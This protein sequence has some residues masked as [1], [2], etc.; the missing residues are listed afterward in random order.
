MTEPS[1]EGRIEECTRRWSVTVDERRDTVDSVLLLGRRGDAH[2]VL[3]VVRRRTDEWES[4]AILSAFAGSAS[5]LALEVTGG[6][7]LLERLLPGS[8]L[9]SLSLSG[10]DDEATGILA[11][12]IDRM[13]PLEPPAVA[14]PVEDLARGFDRYLAGT[15]RRIDGRLVD[16]AHRIYLSL[17]RTQSRPRL[18]HGDLHHYNVLFDDCRGWTAIDPKGYVG[19]LE[20]ELGASLRNPYEQPAVFSGLDAVNR[21]LALL[22]QALPVNQDRALAWAYAQAVLAVIWS[23][24]D[25]TAVEAVDPCLTLARAIEPVLAVRDT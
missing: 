17:C 6:A 3:K 24:E 7:V 13:R 25:G 10:R 23:V 12:V 15:D 4:G 20:Y 9:A 18:L 5:V 14:V 22:A 19:E 11:D 8:A 2:V 1:L 16:N 21:R